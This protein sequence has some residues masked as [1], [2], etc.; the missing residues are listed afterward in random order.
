MGV[1]VSTEKVVDTT[2]NVLSKELKR[3][4]GF[5]IVL[6]LLMIGIFGNLLQAIP[7]I[8][9][10]IF[11]KMIYGLVGTVLAFIFVITGSFITYG[12]YRLKK[13]AWTLGLPWLLFEAINGFLAL[14]VNPSISITSLILIA[15]S[16][17]VTSIPV[18]LYIL[19]KK[20]YFIC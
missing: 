6:I 13:I 17:L 16:L 8:P 1:K 18:L 2:C 14:F 20:E 10:F 11:G 4:I 3:P 7:Q 9:A 19:S 12:F 5:N 15:T